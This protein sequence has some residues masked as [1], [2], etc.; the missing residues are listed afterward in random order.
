MAS[1]DP[2]NELV[3]MMHGTDINNN[4]YIPNKQMYKSA[5]KKKEPPIQYWALSKKELDKKDSAIQK[6]NDQIKEKK[7]DL[8]TVMNFI[9][10]GVRNDKDMRESYMTKEVLEME[11]KELNDK[12]ILVASSVLADMTM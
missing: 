12:L 2:V 3:R 4:R 5:K 1:R 10:M 8:E 9:D 7:R 11:I 6:I